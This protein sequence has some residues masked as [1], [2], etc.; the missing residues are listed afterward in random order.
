[1]AHGHEEHCKYGFHA[2]TRKLLYSAWVMMLP[3]KVS[4]SKEFC[5]VNPRQHCAAR[6][7]RMPARACVSARACA[8]CRR[9]FMV[10][11]SL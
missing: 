1:M 3:K 4:S 2:R 10:A 6:E 8:A 11:C 9:V 7:P 5:R